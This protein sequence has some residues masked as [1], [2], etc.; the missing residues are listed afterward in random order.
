MAPTL[1]R[2]RLETYVSTMVDCLEQV[3]AAW[4]AGA[5]RNMLVEMRRVTLLILMQTLFGVDFR[6]DLERLWPAIIRSLAYISPGAWLVW[7]NLPRPA[8]RQALRQMD[9]YLLQLIRARRNAPE[10]GGDDLLTLLVS[11]PEMSDDLIRDQLLTML[12]A[13]HDTGT[14]LLAWTLYL[15]GRHPWA[16]ARLRAEI[17]SVL[18]EEQ[19]TYEQLRH[20]RYLEQVIKESLRL[21]P[22]IHLGQRIAATDLTFQGYHIP[23]GTRVIYSIYLTH[24][25]KAYWPE[26]ARFEPDR[27]N[28]EQSQRVVAHTYIPFGGGARNCIGAGFGLVEAKV[29]LARLIQQFDLIL[30]G[31]R[32]KPHLGATLNPWPGVM[33]QALRRRRS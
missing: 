29:V 28:P 19:P 10:R 24:R 1:H 21:Y 32:V 8:Y 6:P 31:D 11:V 2:R 33:M 3:C 16:L 5:P 18:G 12:I 23:A 22:P 13:G 9:D 25:H 15:I 17:E 30:T 4:D 27:F 26:P 14:A 20:L 7:P